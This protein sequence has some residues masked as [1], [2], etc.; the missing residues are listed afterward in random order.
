MFMAC[1]DRLFTNKYFNEYHQTD[2]LVFV[3]IVLLFE[4]VFGYY[5]NKITSASQD[6]DIGVLQEWTR[7]NIVFGDNFV[8]CPD[9]GML[10]LRNCLQCKFINNEHNVVDTIYI[11]I[12][13]VLYYY[14]K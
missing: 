5:I 12:P 6:Y 8:S 13:S 2:K 11:N 10:S 3:N 9:D 4:H 7:V 1:V 14:Q